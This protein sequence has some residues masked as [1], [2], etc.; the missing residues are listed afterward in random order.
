VTLAL[1]AINVAVFVFELTA[2]Q[3]HLPT[4]RGKVFA[5]DGQ[6]AITAE[7]GFVPCELRGSCPLGSDTV[8]FGANAP[9]RVHHVPV[10]ATVFTS[11]FVHA[12]WA[13]LGFNML[14]LWVFGSK[15][16]DR[17]GR[18]RFLI[19]YLLGGVAALGLQFLA[20]PGSAVA[21]IGAS[22]AIAAVLA[23]YLL[24]Y[25]RALIL[26]LVGWIPIPL[27]AVVFLLIWIL[28]QVAG[29]AGSIGQAT[30]GGDSI[31]YMAHVGGFAFGLLAIRRFDPGPAARP[32]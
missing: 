26:T 25:P 24:L 29:A 16:E 5:V 12:G 27:P 14:F 10:V 22:G 20:D 8:D 3:Q 11:M 7:Y 13:H 2:P 15:V 32:A 19:F 31:A 4:T 9:F 28:L 6:S 30:G 23:G 1:I 21:T 17:L 18:A